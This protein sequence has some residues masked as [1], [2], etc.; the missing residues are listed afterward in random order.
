M[1]TN[2]PPKQRTFTVAEVQKALSR[3]VW[4]D[5]SLRH[6]IIK[7]P[8]EVIERELEIQFPEHINVKVIDLT[9]ENIVY[10]FLPHHPH[11]VYGFELT[12]AQMEHVAGAGFGNYLQTL[13]SLAQHHPLVF[14][15][16]I[17][18]S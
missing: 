8:K 6:E 3:L 11:E 15:P 14:H 13:S 10:F 16:K 7:N 4:D 12:S 2:K 1:A 18:H 17:K 9:E 5:E